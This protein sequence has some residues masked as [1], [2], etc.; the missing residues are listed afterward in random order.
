MS[1]TF[2]RRSERLALIAAFALLAS[3]CASSGPTPVL[4][5]APELVDV[6]FF[7]QT[8]YDCGPAALATI[9]NAA[10][11][12]VTPAELIDDVYIEGL[13]GSLQA[14]LFGATRRFGLLPVPVPPDAQSLL[15]EVTAGRPVLVLQNLGFERFPAWH[16][17]VVVGYSAERARV[18]LRSGDERRRQ[19][20]A[21]RFLKRWRRADNWGFVAVEPGQIP[22]SAT[23]DGY[24]RA[25]VGSARQLDA[26]G[27]ETA[28]A[29]ALERWPDDPLVLF[30]TA[31]WQQSSRRLVS[32]ERLYRRLLALEPEHA[33]ARNNLAN[34][35][36][37]LGCRDDALRE[38]HAALALQST[39]DAFFDAI[40][41]T[42]RDIEA[43]PASTSCPLS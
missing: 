34:L 33:A 32:A 2:S 38:A 15:T 7:P 31:S 25:L 28:Y 4:T 36:L 41:G 42:V 24:M 1:S 6:P 20:R 29:A 17:A 11:V 18:V 16:Y 39:E 8:E 23:A 9:L 26:A 12:A 30:L 5:A 14:E 3:A 19:E 13:R 27:V 35:L 10:D 37:D 22:A 21:R 40:A 43:A